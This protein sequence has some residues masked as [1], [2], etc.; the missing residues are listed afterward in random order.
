MNP[1]ARYIY[2]PKIGR[3]PV[4]SP[5]SLKYKIGF[6]LQRKCPRIFDCRRGFFPVSRMSAISFFKSEPGFLDENYDNRRLQSVVA[7]NQFLEIV[8]GIK[9]RFP[10]RGSRI[11]EI[12][13]GR[14]ELIGLLISSGCHSCFRSLCARFKI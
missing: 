7:L 13:C 3:V 10:K 1:Y 9:K 6:L 12:G 8:A 11:V 14:G 4:S 2:R 5:T